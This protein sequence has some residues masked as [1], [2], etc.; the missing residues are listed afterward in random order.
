MSIRNID[1]IID[2]K[3]H[4]GSG[5]SILIIGFENESSNWLNCAITV[6][7]TS[8]TASLKT[9]FELSEFNSFYTSLITSLEQ[10]NEKAIFESCEGWLNFTI[11]FNKLGQAIV[12]GNVN[13]LNNKLNFYFDTDQSYI[14]TTI[15]QL[16]CFINK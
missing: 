4:N 6:N 15:S 3:G 7:L 9:S 1:K 5:I 13:D 11:S 14:Q 12:E 16:K 2:I 8:F 10:L